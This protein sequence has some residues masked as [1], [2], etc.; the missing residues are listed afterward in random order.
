MSECLEVTESV[1]KLVKGKTPRVI[2][3]VINTSAR[4]IC[5]KKGSIIG[6]ISSLDAIIP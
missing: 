1:G 6:E 5:L 4:D 3:E 2:V